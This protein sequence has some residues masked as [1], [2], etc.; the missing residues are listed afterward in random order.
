MKPEVRQRIVS[1]LALVFVIG[2]SVLL[3]LNRGRIQ[4]NIPVLEALNAGKAVV[5]A[6]KKLLAEFGE[7]I[8]GL[9]AKKGVDVRFQDLERLTKIPAF[10]YGVALYSLQFLRPQARQRLVSAIA[11]AIEPGGGFFV[12]EKVL[13]SYP[14]TQAIIQ[15]LY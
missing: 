14:T 13:G 8:F 6:N 5:T 9:A 7:E 2:L 10:S 4:E 3:F 1:V 15:Q 11:E 12:V